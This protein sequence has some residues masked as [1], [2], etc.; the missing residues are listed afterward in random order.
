MKIIDF[1]RKIFPDYAVLPFI[2]CGVGQLVAYYVTR[3]INY[4]FRGMPETFTDIAS[5]FDKMI[6]VM[7]IWSVIYFLSYVF[8]AVSY[9]WVG[10]ESKEICN[11]MLVADM[12]GKILCAAVFIIFPTTLARP[13]VDT[14][15]FD[16]W[17]L[18]YIYTIDQPDNLLPSMHCSVSWF[19]A[20]FVG[21]SRIIPKWYKIFAFV[22]AFL[23]FASVLFTKQHVIVDI[24]A[25]VFVAELCTQI[26]CRT[27]LHRLYDKLDLGRVYG[28]E[29]Q[30]SNR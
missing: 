22:S 7:P 4:S 6:P 27:N 29:K 13:T 30:T 1:R 5:D 18:N 12:M 14:S 25:G 8:W 3:I 28:R 9:I 24:F 23:V 17:L 10:R 2:L 19:A 20:R 16:G 21:K 26:S 11:K 15:S